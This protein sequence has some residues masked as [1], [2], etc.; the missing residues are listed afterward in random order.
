[1]ACDRRFGCH[2]CVQTLMILHA[3]IRQTLGEKEIDHER[4]RK[5]LITVKRFIEDVVGV[6]EDSV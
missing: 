2:S 1:M 4:I 3:S 5:Q 6:G